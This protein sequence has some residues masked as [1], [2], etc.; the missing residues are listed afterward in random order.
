M[1]SWYPSFVIRTTKN[2][3]YLL[4]CFSNV[5]LMLGCCVFKNLSASDWQL[6]R[7]IIINILSIPNYFTFLKCIQPQSFV[8]IHEKISQDKRL[9]R[10]KEIYVKIYPSGS[11]LASIYGLLKIHKLNVQWNNLFLCPI[12]SSIGTYNY[13]LSKSL[14]DLLDPVIPTSHCT[15]DSFT[16]CEEIKKVNAANRFL[17]SYDVC[18]YLLVYHSKKRLILLLICYLNIIWI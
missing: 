13:H 10:K 8:I 9:A 1:K 2:E 18:S 17:I 11:K 16:F 5:N 6:K 4:T 15:K 14:T 3:I 7:Q 12:V